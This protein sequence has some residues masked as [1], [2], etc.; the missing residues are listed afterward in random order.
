LP[1]A[2]TLLIVGWAASLLFKWL[3]PDSRVGSVLIALGLGAAGSEVIGYLLGIGLVLLALVALG[4]LVD[5]G[6]QHGMARLFGSVVRRIPL[7][8]MV[9]D[10]AHKLVGLIRQRDPGAARSMRAVWCNF[11][12]AAVLGLQTSPDVLMVD[13]RRCVVV[14]VPTAP[15]PVGGGLLFLP[16]AWVRDADLS[17]EAVT[18][19]YVSMGVTAGQYLPAAPPPLGNGLGTSTQPTQPQG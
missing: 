6:L 7:V 12:G 18:S 11:G 15:V 16:E 4:A 10:L 17:V 13:G 9:Y 19:L 14:L 8:G 5:A 2:A 1:L 3:G